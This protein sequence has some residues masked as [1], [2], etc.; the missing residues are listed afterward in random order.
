MHP[1]VFSAAV[2]EGGDAASARVVSQHDRI[3]TEK[4]EEWANGHLR[5]DE[6][7]VLEAS[8]N[9]FAVAGR[10]HAVGITAV[11]LES[12]QA[13]KIRHNFCNDDRQSAVK[14]A[15][16]YLSGLAKEVWQ[17]DEETRA[18]REIFF[19][20]RNAV[21]DTTRN[22]NR[23]RSYLN[24]HCV[25]LPKGT[26]LTQESGLLRALGAREWS[27]LQER[28]IRSLFKQLWECESRRTDL[29]QLMV[30]ELI[31]RPQWAQLWR[32]MGIRH[33]VA[34]ALMAV[35]GDIHRFPTAKKL[36]GYIGL[37]P[38]RKQSGTNAKGYEQGLSHAGRNDLRT[39]VLQS[40]QNALTQRNSPLHKWGWRLLLRKNRNLAAVA[41]G[42]KLVVAVWHLLMGH[43]TP[44]VELTDHI[45]TKLLQI[46]TVLGK[47]ILKDMGFASRSEFV[48]KQ[49]QLWQ[50]SS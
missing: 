50:L 4:L 48:H 25:R 29:E 34:F 28:L 5:G 3:G 11:V 14:L 43:F 33:R 49:Y 32:L 15:R 16:V 41:V 17:P 44:L 22:R 24:E 27:P 10:L 19:A 45:H 38:R 36:V 39:L 1:D 20:H 37:S 18:M 8:G 7:V 46:A 35:I 13:G 40:A 30:Q 9:S 31:A 42:R 12:V 47:P 26:R 21:K 23:I 2:L 6:I